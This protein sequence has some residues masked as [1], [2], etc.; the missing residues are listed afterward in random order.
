MAGYRLPLPAT[1]I[2]ANDHPCPVAPHPCPWPRGVS[3]Q[4]QAGELP[5][6]LG[7]ETG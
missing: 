4:T 1:S 7:V 3:A 5:S 6:K 2:H